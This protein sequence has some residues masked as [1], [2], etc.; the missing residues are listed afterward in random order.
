MSLY[1]KYHVPR[2]LLRMLLLL[3]LEIL[4][5]TPLFVIPHVTTQN[6]V[7]HGK[8]FFSGFLG[9]TTAA[10]LFLLVIIRPR[11]ITV[12]KNSVSLCFLGYALAIFLSVAFSGQ[13]SYSFKHA[14]YV[15]PLVFI[16]L[17]APVILDSPVKIRK[18]QILI[19]ITGFVITAAGFLQYFGWRPINEILRYRI[20]EGRARNFMISTVGNP[21]YLGGFLAPLVLLA[22][23][24]VFQRISIVKKILFFLLT[25]F[26]LIGLFL[27]GSRG[28]I[29]GLM[30]GGIFLLVY[31][32]RIANESLRRKIPITLLVI[33]ACIAA[34]VAI[35]SFPNPLN[36]RNQKIMQRFFNLANPRSES[37]KER[38]L[39]YSIGS[40][41]IMERPVFGKGQGMFRVEFYPALQ[42]LEEKDER[43]GVRRFIT[44]LENRVADYTHND[45]LQIWI[46]NGT[47]GFLC[48][49]LG[50]FLL[51]YHAL[52]ALKNT[53][54]RPGGY[55]TSLGFSAALICLLVNAA[56]S[57]PMQTPS[58]AVLFWIL[59]GA[60]Y[61]ASLTYQ[62]K[63]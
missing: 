29:I 49:T 3:I 27:T 42:K 51:L 63:S 15:W 61:S 32:Y 60:V 33:F 4:F 26:F 46:E 24:N 45:Y 1:R 59:M 9:C 18:L 28:P 57:F 11:T 37:V 8:F 17:F 12:L 23:I 10:F 50:I 16:F 20:T 19:L 58:R 39:F 40:E 53:R 55:L 56:F 31:L 30:A 2:F 62:T 5:L 54:D 35:F 41:M 6:S 52:R 14:L 25:M 34:V 38:I 47:L 48:F 36:P 13:F 22:G 44:E 21:E 43:A 7:L